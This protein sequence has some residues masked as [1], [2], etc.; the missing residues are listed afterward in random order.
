MLT[1]DLIKLLIDN[2][3][4]YGD[5]PT[6]IVDYGWYCESEGGYPEKIILL[7]TDDREKVKE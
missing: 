6:N 4:K 5:I 1:S 7:E 2:L 3:K